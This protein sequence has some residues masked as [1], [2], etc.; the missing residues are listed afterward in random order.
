MRLR[1]S[2]LQISRKLQAI[3]HLRPAVTFNTTK[4]TDNQYA[5]DLQLDATSPWAYAI[6]PSTAEFITNTP[7][8]N[9][10]PSPI[11]DNGLPPVSILVSACRIDWA[12][13]GDAWV[14]VPPQ[15]ATCKGDTE[16]ITLTPYGV[17]ARNCSLIF[18]S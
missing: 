8:D 1:V 3:T 10:L 11:F 2:T 17:S 6:D 15:N 7:D 4:L 5:P 12:T 16:K 13:A 18:W 9:K 14:E